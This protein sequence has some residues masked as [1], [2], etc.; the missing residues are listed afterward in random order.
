MLTAHTADVHDDS[1]G[2]INDN[3]SAM[4]EG[5]YGTRVCQFW[6]FCCTGVKCPPGLSRQLC[7]E[8]LRLLEVGGVKAL[9]EPAHRLLPAIRRPRSACL[10]AAT[11]ERGWWQRGV[12]RIWLLEIAWLLAG[13]IRAC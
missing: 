13:H 5:L 12:P 7:Q 6:A 4:D 11:G 1:E 9:R 10:A 2:T 8:R 3:R